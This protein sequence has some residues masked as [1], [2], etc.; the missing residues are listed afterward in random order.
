MITTLSGSNTIMARELVVCM[1]CFCGS[2]LVD[3]RAL[4]KLRVVLARKCSWDGSASRYP[5]ELDE[6]I[7]TD[8]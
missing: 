7:G 1:P 2:D 8:G 3:P 6:S 4:R 5:K